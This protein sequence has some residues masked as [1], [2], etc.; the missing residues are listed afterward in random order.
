MALINV[1]HLPILCTTIAVIT[2]H[3]VKIPEQEQSSGTIVHNKNVNIIVNVDTKALAE[4]LWKLI[5]IH[6]TNISDVSSQQKIIE[7]LE[8][9]ITPLISPTTARKSMSSTY[10]VATELDQ[11]TRNALNTYF[12]AT[13]IL[14]KEIM[15]RDIVA[16]MMSSIK[17]FLLKTLK[18]QI[19]PCIKRLTQSRKETRR[20]TIMAPLMISRQIFSCLLV[21]L[22]SQ[23]GDTSKSQYLASIL[24]TLERIEDVFKQAQ[25]NSEFGCVIPCKLLNSALDVPKLPRKQIQA[26]LKKQL[27][28]AQ[29]DSLAF[30]RSLLSNQDVDNMNA[31]ININGIHPF[32][33]RRNFDNSVLTS[34]KMKIANQNVNMWDSYENQSKNEGFENDV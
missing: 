29:V 7:N 9:A 27:P 6:L 3:Q 13:N 25:Q 21:I 1:M 26:N 2:A 33:G 15:T 17:A 8:K 32:E 34:N 28:S 23:Y 10:Q 22:L 12:P 20:L 5:E 24:A 11:I 14:D 30:R 4:E 31:N 18:N 19:I 16:N